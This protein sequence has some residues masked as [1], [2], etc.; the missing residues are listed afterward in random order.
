MTRKVLEV[1]RLEVVKILKAMLSTTLVIIFLLRVLGCDGDSG[2]EPQPRPEG[3]VFMGLA[4]KEVRRVRLFGDYLYACA[5]RDGLYRINV[6]QSGAEWE[7]LGLADS[8]LPRRI[9]GVLDVAVL[10][11]NLV[12]AYS[13]PQAE[14]TGIFRAREGE[15]DWQP[16]D[17]GLGYGVSTLSPSPWASETIFAGI[18]GG[19]VYKSNNFG[20]NWKQVLV[21]AP[22]GP[23]IE[24][25]RFHPIRANE[26]W[27]VGQGFDYAELYRSTDSGE[28]WQDLRRI[29]NVIF[30]HQYGDSSYFPQSLSEIAFDPA[31]ENVI[32]LGSDWLWKSEDGGD[33]WSTTLDT[34][35]VYRTVAINPFNSK[36]ILVSSGSA[37]LIST[38][39]AKTWQ[40]IAL[41][42]PNSVIS[43][44][45][46]DW[47]KRIVYTHIFSRELSRRVL[48]VYKMYF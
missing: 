28:T 17:S 33:T 22:T 42:E 29:L 14:E 12:A 10:N 2:M 27:V 26:I 19:A 1:T 40:S 21:I 8:T 25:I 23:T 41:P 32:Y 5:A 4:D 3:W 7:F 35:G 18:T 15:F 37:L 39:G 24:V 44:I 13:T 9:D 16:S 43:F 47:Q 20:R 30:F 11:D 36:E 48:G 45:E 46:V 31:N 38:N 6:Q 34:V